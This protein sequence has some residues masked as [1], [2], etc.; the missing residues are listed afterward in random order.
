MRDRTIL[1]VE[2]V[3][4]WS[5]DPE[6]PTLGKKSQGGSAGFLHMSIRLRAPVLA[7]G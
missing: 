7:L 1:D 3:M 6:T 2:K 4:D 5:N